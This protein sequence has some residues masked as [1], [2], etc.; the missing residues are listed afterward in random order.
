MELLKEL[1]I[2][3]LLT[4]WSVAIGYVAWLMQQTRTEAKETAKEQKKNAAQA[5]AQMV[6]IKAGIMLILRQ[7]LFDYHRRFCIEGERMEAV[8]YDH[9]VEVHDA[10]TALGG[11]G[12]GEKAFKELK[13]VSLA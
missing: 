1:I 5:D 3:G 2:P 10:Y 4:F 11:N 9:I 8:D 13:E 12:T 7:E 6:A